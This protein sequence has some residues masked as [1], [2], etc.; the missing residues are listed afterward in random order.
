MKIF[1]WFKRRTTHLS[2]MGVLIGSLFFALSLTP[3]L[4]PRDYLFQGVLAGLC[5]ALGYGCGSFIRWVWSFLELPEPKRKFLIFV[6]RL[7]VIV[8][9]IILIYCLWNS[10]YWQNSIRE[11]MGMELL[12]SSHAI[13]VGFIGLALAFIL[14]LVSQYIYELTSY[15]NQKLSKIL[16]RRV[17]LIIGPLFIAVFA[18]NIFNGVIVKSI[19]HV[20]D[21]SFQKTDRFFADGQTAPTSNLASGSPNSIV[22][23]QDLGR[24]GRKFVHS[25]PTL[26]QISEY[27]NQQAQQPLRIYVGLNSAATAKARAKLALQEMLRVK[28]FSRKILVIAN[29]TGTGWVDPMSVDTLEYMHGGDTA[30]VSMQYSYLASWLSLLA[31]PEV[32]AQSAKALFN[33]VYQHWTKLPKDARPKLFLNGLSLGSLGSEQSANLITMLSDPINGALWAGPPFANSVWRSLT[34]SRNEGSPAWLPIIGDSSIV[35]FTSQENA[36]DIPNAK[37]GVMRIVYI[38]HASD[39]IVFFDMKSAFQQP[40]WM[41]GKRGPDVSPELRWYPVVTFVQLLLDMATAIIPPLG[42][43]HTYHPN[44]YIDGWAEVTAPENWSEVQS[45]QL[46]AVFTGIVKHE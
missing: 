39:G 13:S 33:E 9:G 43:G 4:I 37:W 42:Y 45:K 8:I 34:D 17:A 19:M 6:R 44:G 30:I 27:S 1:N 40:E 14:I 32:S 20:M 10:V 23:W 15:A 36:L 2:F 16:P 38:Q 3:S 18:L 28:A 21:A 12:T 22:N 29:P 25:G 11:L 46:K 35:R 7:T 26:Q 31:E 24:L 5:F 41:I